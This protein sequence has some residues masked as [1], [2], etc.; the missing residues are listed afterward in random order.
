MDE[1]G[2]THISPH[3]TRPRGAHNLLSHLPLHSQESSRA[4]NLLIPIG[5]I[6]MIQP[7][8]LL[9]LYSLVSSPTANPAGTPWR[10]SDTPKGRSSLLLCQDSLKETSPSSRASPTDPGALGGT[11]GSSQSDT[12]L[13]SKSKGCVGVQQPSSPG[14]ESKH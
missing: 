4:P 8:S 14:M 9:P 2:P 11:S 1:V 3:P 13:H 5:G 6:H 10:R 12:L 7:R